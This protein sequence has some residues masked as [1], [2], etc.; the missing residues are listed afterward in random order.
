MEVATAAIL[1]MVLYF[2]AMALYYSIVGC[3]REIRWEDYM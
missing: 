3:P 1:A 2:G